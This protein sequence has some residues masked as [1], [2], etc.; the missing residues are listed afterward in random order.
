MT[1]IKCPACGKLEQTQI[2]TNCGYVLQPNNEYISADDNYQL[3]EEYYEE[4]EYR[5]LSK[6]NWGAFTLAPFWGFGNGI[7]WLC[8]IYLGILL[9][10]TLSFL[11]C[12][13]Y[14]LPI[15]LIIFLLILT[16]SLYT[17]FVGN[18]LSWQKK[19][20]ND[21]EHFIRV[22][23]LW[24]NVGLTIIMIGLFKAILILAYLLYC[25]IAG[26]IL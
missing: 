17:G 9:L 16:C 26:N 21:I 12:A 3:E 11:Y 24:T 15:L 18:R 22:Q 7:P 13:S 5:Q 4:A 23:E 25:S 10:G 19:K 20:W 2:C 6:F 14:L 8:L 1:D